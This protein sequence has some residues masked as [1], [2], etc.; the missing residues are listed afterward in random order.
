MTTNLNLTGATKLTNKEMKKVK[1]GISAKEYCANMHM[2]LSNPD[3]IANMSDGEIHGAAYGWNKA[4][5][6]KW[7]NDIKIVS[8]ECN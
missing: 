2:I 6:D 5:C 8:P 4:G 3:N 7:Y 1:G